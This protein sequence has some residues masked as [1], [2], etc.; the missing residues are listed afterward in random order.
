MSVIKI[1]EVN[2]PSAEAPME[3]MGNMAIRIGAYWAFKS[4]QRLGESD[5]L[6]MFRLLAERNHYMKWSYIMAGSTAL[7]VILGVVFHA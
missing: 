5:D 1:R 4:A 2:K 6:T 7:A 3:R